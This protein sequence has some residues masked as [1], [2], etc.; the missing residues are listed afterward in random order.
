MYCVA[1]RN[2]VSVGPNIVS[3]IDKPLASET[4]GLGDNSSGFTKTMFD[5]RILDGVRTESY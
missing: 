2:N 4:R 3:I 5:V 1:A